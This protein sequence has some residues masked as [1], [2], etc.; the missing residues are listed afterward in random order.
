VPK[1]PLI[2][3]TRVDNIDT[4]IEESPLDFIIESPLEIPLSKKVF[5]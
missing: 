3:E 5:F 1:R 2:V 4:P